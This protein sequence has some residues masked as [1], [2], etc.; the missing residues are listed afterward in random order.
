MV[1]TKSKVKRGEQ[2]QRGKDEK[3]AKKDIE[4]CSTI[5]LNHLNISTEQPLKNLAKEG[6]CNTSLGVNWSYYGIS[7][8]FQ[9]SSTSSATLLEAHS[10]LLQSHYRRREGFLDNIRKRRISG[11]P[12][13]VWLRRAEMDCLCQAIGWKRKR[14]SISSCKKHRPFLTS[15]RSCTSA[16]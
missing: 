5:L 14:E 3:D 16:C 8:T 9:M 6:S 4:R 2:R 13:Q 1:P 12:S 10:G 11:I 15:K 7:R